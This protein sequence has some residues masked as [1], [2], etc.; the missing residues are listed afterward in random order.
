MHNWVLVLAVLGSGA[1]LLFPA[2]TGG[3][4]QGGL[5]VADAVQKMNREKAVMVDVREAAEYAQ[6]RIAQ[7]KHIPL[8]ELAEKLPQTV[9]NKNTPVLFM[10]STGARSGRAAAAAKKLGYEQAYSV[11]GGLRSW[12]SANMPVS[13]AKA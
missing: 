10:C 7:S 3:A 8:S 13:S 12:K 6:E 2:I 1:M 4:T 9:K 5:P 11:A